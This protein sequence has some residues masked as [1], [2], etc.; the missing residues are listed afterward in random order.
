VSERRYDNFMTVDELKKK[1]KDNGIPVDAWGT[2]ST[3]P[4]GVLQR[5]R[6]LL[7]KLEAVLVQ[8]IEA[9]Q[10]KLAELKIA[11]HKAKNGGAR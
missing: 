10:K 3:N 8:Q 9:D 5:E 4:D 11:L 7:Q 2:T 6:D 1:L